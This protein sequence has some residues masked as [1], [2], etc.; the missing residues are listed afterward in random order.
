MNLLGSRTLETS[1][2]MIH[3]TEE[4]DLQKLWNILKKEEVSKYYLVTKI[5][6]DWEK[7]KKWQYKKLEKANSSDI[8]CWTIILK[9]TGEVIGQISVQEKKDA[10]K[11]IRDIGWFI[12]TKFQKKGYAYEVALEVLKY[13]FLEVEIEKIETCAAIDNPNSWKL[14]EKLGFKR[15]KTTHYEKYTFVEEKVKVYEYKCTKN[16]FLKEYFKLQELY[17][18]EDIDKDPYIKHISDDFV[19]N[20]TGESGSGKSTACEKYRNNPDCI[21]I[22]MDELQKKDTKDLFIKELLTYFLKKYHKIPSVIEEFDLLYKETLDY[23]KNS[24]KMIIIDSTQFR[25]LQDLTLLKGDII[26]L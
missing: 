12:D 4:N 22:D 11:E 5:N 8:F 20:I 3:K 15:L 23:Y 10:K 16:D 21:I 25:N 6:N 13:M 24:S 17:I 26:V 19:L 18:T 14:M 1:R 7:E 9:E 2:L